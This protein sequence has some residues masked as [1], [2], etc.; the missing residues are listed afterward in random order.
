MSNSSQATMHA[1]G[2]AVAAMLLASCVLDSSG[3]LAPAAGANGGSGPGPGGTAGSGHSP[4]GGT[5]GLPAGGGGSST[6]TAGGGGALGGGGAAPGPEDCLNGV[7]DNGDGLIDC[8]DPDCVAAGY[9]CLP[10]AA[11]ALSYVALGTPGPSCLSPATAT[12]FASCQGCSCTATPGTCTVAF[13]A[14]YAVGC[15]GPNDGVSAGCTNQSGNIDQLYWTATVGPAG[16][17]SCSPQA[18]QMAA[19]QTPTCGLALPGNCG[20]GAVCVPPSFAAAQRCV[21]MP[22]ASSCPAEYPVAQGAGVG[23]TSCTCT[24]QEGGV[25]CAPPD[26]VGYDGWNCTGN[27]SS[28]SIGAPCTY[29]GQ[30]LSVSV[31]GSVP[32]P[33]DC[34]A[35]GVVSD[36]SSPG[37]LCCAS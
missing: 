24:C 7:D 19:S 35:S 16:G 27:P 12:D 11:G 1:A 25:Q 5:G 15:G 33:V 37:V 3:L 13:R 32:A 10:V 23:G 29:S 2:L 8:D 30:P 36:P 21:L 14:W 20:A 26:I 28:T 34:A 22:A 18:E 6:T 9:L 31:P 17:Q 4:T